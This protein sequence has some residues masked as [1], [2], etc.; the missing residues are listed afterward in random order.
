MEVLDAF[1]TFDAEHPVTRPGRIRYLLAPGADERPD[2]AAFRERMRALPR[3]AGGLLPLAW[4]GPDAF[5]DPWWKALLLRPQ[6]G[7][8]LAGERVLEA[9]ASASPAPVVIDAGHEG[10]SR[11]DHLRA[12]LDRCPPRP[13]VLTHGGQLNISG[14]HL[15]AAAE[16]FRRH[17]HTLL[18]TSG[19]YRQDF[20]EAMLDALGPGRILYGSGYPL[21]DEEMEQA[22]V[23][24]L[25]AGDAGRQAILGGNAARIFGV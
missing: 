25:P 17:P 13:V 9:L 1:S 10:Y 20:L 23:E 19:I 8:P 18:E 22:R 21:M 5:A 6:D 11:P 15:E 7:I 24:L 14:A 4:A 2:P 16:L 12:F 3:T